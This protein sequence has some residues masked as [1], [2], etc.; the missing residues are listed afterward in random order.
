MKIL[1][2]R[3]KNSD[4]KIASILLEEKSI[5]ILPTDTVY[6]LFATVSKENV[7]LINSVK[8]RKIDQPLSIMFSSL[9][10]AYEYMEVGDED[11]NILESNLPSKKTFVVKLKKGMIKDFDDAGKK[12][13]GVRIIDNDF[14]RV[15]SIIK[16]TGPLL[17]T[18]CNET[19]EPPLVSDEEIKNAFGEKPEVKIF[20]KSGYMMDGKK[21][22]KVFD[23][24]NSK[25]IKVIR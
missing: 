4:K 18:S 19:G 6:G 8:G 22:T 13:I 16:L 1:K 14:P 20:A 21:P 9:K 7:E 24:T 23:I 15:K 25:Q 17:A 11:K 2:I 10:E 3:T 5:A 12:E